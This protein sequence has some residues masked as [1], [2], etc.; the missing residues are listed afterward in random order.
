MLQKYQQEIASHYMDQKKIVDEEKERRQDLRLKY[1]RAAQL[2]K[3]QYRM[4]Q[5]HLA[6]KSCQ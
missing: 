3:Y 4:T 6:G 5:R 1:R 2:K